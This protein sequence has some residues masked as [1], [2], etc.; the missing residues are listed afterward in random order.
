MDALARI[1]EL[2]ARGHVRFTFHARVR[3]DERNVS[4]GDVCN[5]LATATKADHQMA[6]DNY[7]VSGGTDRDGEP[8]VVVV[9]IEADAVI[10]TIF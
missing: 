5:A 4:A 9:A 8:L 6:K 7:R 1:K 2:V 10:I 3:M